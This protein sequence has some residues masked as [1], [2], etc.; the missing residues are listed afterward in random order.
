MDLL[1]INYFR[2]SP[3]KLN[4]EPLNLPYS[5]AEWILYLLGMEETMTRTQ[6]CEILWGDMDEESARRNLRNAIYVIKKATGQPLVQ[7]MGKHLLGL[8]P[9]LHVLTDLNALRRTGEGLP[10]FPDF[11]HEDFLQSRLPK[12]ESGLRDW[13]LQHQETCRDHYINGLMERIRSLTDDDSKAMVCRRILELDP[14]HEGALLELFR[15]TLKKGKTNQAIELYNAYKLRLGLEYGIAPSDEFQDIFHSLTDQCCDPAQMGFQFDYVDRNQELATLRQSLT[16]FC[17]GQKVPSL[18]LCGEPGSGKTRLLSELAL[19]EPGAGSPCV[20]LKLECYPHESVYPLFH[21]SALRDSLLDGP[22][23]QKVLSALTRAGGFASEFWHYATLQ[24][25]DPLTLGARLVQALRAMDPPL[26]LVLLV[27]NFADLD[28]STQKVLDYLLSAQSDR[29]FCVLTGRSPDILDSPLLVHLQERGNLQKIL[30]PRFSRTESEAL[31][32]R[33]ATPEADPEALIRLSQG[34]PFFLREAIYRTNQKLSL[35]ELS[36]CARNLTTSLYRAAAPAERRLLEACALSR[37][38]L[39]L[40]DLSQVLQLDPVECTRLAESLYAKQQIEWSA[41]PLG[42]LTVRIWH[43]AYVMDLRGRLS[44][45]QTRAL[46]GALFSHWS[47]RFLAEPDNRGLLD[48]MIYHATACQNRKQILFCKTTRMELDF[49]IYHEVFPVLRAGRVHDLVWPTATV[50]DFSQ[51]FDEVLALYKSMPQ[52]RQ[53][54]MI[55]LYL[56]LLYIHGR[57]YKDR[58]IYD[59]GLG[60]IRKMIQ[61]AQLHQFHAMAFKGYIQLIHHCI[62]QAD[63]TGMSEII[64]LVRDSLWEQLTPFDQMMLNKFHGFSLLLSGHQSQGEV[65]LSEVLDFYT[66]QDILEEY[67]LCQ[68]SVHFFLGEGARVNGDL[69]TALDH[70]EDA[71]SLCNEESD[72]ATMAILLS[73]IGTLQYQLGET[74]AALF[75]LRRSVACYD[76]VI[77]SWG[78]QEAQELLSRLTSSPP[79]HR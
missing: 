53:P 63:Y 40:E 70:Y 26:R 52:L 14:F 50:D 32:T 5:K 41:D 35:S 58:G 28:E 60:S 75:Y 44:E 59:S 8:E 62:N 16:D 43:P 13:I 21:L 69:P 74:D 2:L 4:Q 7:S 68:A 24:G 76:S 67:A 29:F 19:P 47:A 3:I 55:H 17:Q 23:R 64:N 79:A 57:F 38:P 20:A 61:I 72:L 10:A 15:L 30:L 77:F 56:R 73:R 25:Q 22:Y 37:R 42:S 39:T 65:L 51:R 78:R 45:S 18:Y 33:Y 31:I 46:H 36:D 54:D 9:N 11:Y 12:E 71:M 34:S 6:L 66:R 27:D 49:D 48:E 1:E